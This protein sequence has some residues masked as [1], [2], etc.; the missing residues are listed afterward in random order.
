[1]PSSSTR[2]LLGRHREA[3]WSPRVRSKFVPEVWPPTPR[4][5][6]F[7]AAGTWG[8]G[9]CILPL[10]TPEKHTTVELEKQSYPYACIPT[11]DGK[12]LFVSLWNKAAIAV[13]DLQEKKV[14]RH[15]V[16]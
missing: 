3:K 11:S 2:A 8:D 16:H 1:M 5:R 9:V 10:D 12:R 4:A 14:R 15:V 7:F 13:I 6:C